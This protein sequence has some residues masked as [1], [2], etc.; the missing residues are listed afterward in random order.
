MPATHALPEVRCE[1]GMLVIADLHLDAAL[2]VA[3]KTA[4]ANDC[5]VDARLIST[6]PEM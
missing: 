3:R 4:V 1:T 2:D 5:G 6:S